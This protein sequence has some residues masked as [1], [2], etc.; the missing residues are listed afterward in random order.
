VCAVGNAKNAL[1]EEL[2]STKGA[3]AYEGSRRLAMELREHGLKVAVVSAS[4]N[5]TAILR[6]VGMEGLFDAQIDGREAARL[7]L[8]GKPH[9]DPFLEAARRLEVDPSKTI[10]VEDALSGVEAGRAGDF[11]LVIGVDRHDDPESLREHGADL[12]VAD[13]SELL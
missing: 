8:R 5:C 2:I 12:V 6:S 4:A 7:G 13:L 1:V 3:D 9:P 10:V 11:G